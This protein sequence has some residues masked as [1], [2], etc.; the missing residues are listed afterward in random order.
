MSIDW[1]QKY[2][3][4]DVCQ[5]AM[6][7]EGSGDILVSGTVKSSTSDPLIVYW[8]ASPPTYSTAYSGSG[9]PYPNPEVAYNRTSNSGAIRAENRRFS[10]RIKYPNSYY[11]GLG[12]LYVPPHVHIKVCEPGMNDKYFSVQI[13][14]GIPFRTLT[15]PAPPSNKPRLSAIFYHEPEQEARSQEQILYDGGYPETNTMPD[16]F[17]GLRPPK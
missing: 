3:N 17:W 9:L 4:K 5:G 10:F 1:R 16:N 2:F 12:S 13:D 15:Y 11:V 14:D 7:N 8:A 6:I